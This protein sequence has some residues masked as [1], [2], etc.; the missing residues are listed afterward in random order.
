MGLIC[1]HPA[2]EKCGFEAQRAVATFDFTSLCFAAWRAVVLL[3]VAS[4]ALFQQWTVFA[5][6]GWRATAV[7]DN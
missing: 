6:R 3:E 1:L 4:S 7:L 2:G 5:V